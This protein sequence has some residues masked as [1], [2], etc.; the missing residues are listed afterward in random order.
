MQLDEMTQQ[1]AALVEQASAASQ[2]MAGQAKALNVMMEK[3]QVSKEMAASAAAAMSTA[4]E[5]GANR[6]PA[7][8]A[9]AAA[10]AERRAPERP[11]NAGD[12]KPLAVVKTRPKVGGATGTDSEWKE[13]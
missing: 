13:F 10:G 7:R 8:A 2:S 11:W 12:K 6:K 1:N 4:G 9:T 3:F 5:S